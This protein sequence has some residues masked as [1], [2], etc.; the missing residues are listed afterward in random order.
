MDT[1]TTAHVAGIVITQ[2]IAK[3]K[4]SV[5]DIQSELDRSADENEIRSVLVQIERDGWIEKHSSSSFEAWHSGP[6][7]LEYG[8]MITHSEDIEGNIPVLPDER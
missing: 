6:L 5:T 7:A 8:N 2:A 4:F 1:S 3:S